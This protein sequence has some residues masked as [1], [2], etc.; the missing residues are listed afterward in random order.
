MVGGGQT[1]V[2]I[3]CFNLIALSVFTMKP[4]RPQQLTVQLDN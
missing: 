4:S 1:L 2:K 3:N